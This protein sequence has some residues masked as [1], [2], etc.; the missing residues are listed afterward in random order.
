MMYV[1]GDFFS[2][3]ETKPNYNYCITRK[4]KLRLG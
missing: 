4:E 2:G 1:A 3:V